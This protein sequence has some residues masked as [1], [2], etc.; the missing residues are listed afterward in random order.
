M[1]CRSHMNIRADLPALTCHDSIGLAHHIAHRDRAEQHDQI[2]IGEI[3][4]TAQE[5]YAFGHFHRIG[6]AIVRR[7]PGQ[8]IDDVDVLGAIERDRREH[9]V[10]KFSRRL[11]PTKTAGRSLWS[12]TAQRRC[13]G[14]ARRERR[15]A[16]SGVGRDLLERLAT[17]IGFERGFEVRQRV[18]ARRMIS[19]AVPISSPST[20]RCRRFGLLRKRGRGA[21]CKCWPL[22]RHGGTLGGL[23]ARK[24]S[25][26]RG[27]FRRQPVH[28]LLADSLIRPS[29]DQPGEGGKGVGVCHSRTLQD[30]TAAVTA[31]R[32][33]P[34][35]PEPH[36]P[37]QS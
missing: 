9:L 27:R 24:I 2:G 33:T 18:R 37:R 13:T 7:P 4:V 10:E 21:R 11:R 6:I 36:K 23:R 22:R 1:P 12:S 16:E 32:L 5:G 26:L 8:D 25:R 19:I 15:S 3:D 17:V 30:A 20:R 14:C 28:R 29:F 31:R 35:G 34:S